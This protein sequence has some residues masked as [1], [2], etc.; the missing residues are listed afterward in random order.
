MANRFFDW[1]TRFPRF[2]LGDAPRYSDFNRVFD[3]I[4]TGLTGTTGF[5]ALPVGVAFG[6]IPFFT[7]NSIVSGTPTKQNY[8]SGTVQ[9]DTHSAFSLATG[10][11]TVPA[12]GAGYY[13]LNAQMEWGGGTNDTIAEI[14]IYK[15]GTQLLA[16]HTLVNGDRNNICR[17]AV[18]ADMLLA[19][20]DYIEIYLRHVSTTSAT[21]GTSAT[22]TGVNFF[23]M[24]Q[25]RANGAQG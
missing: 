11:F 13:N 19:A 3:W 12:T 14:L 20:G 25:F 21:R 9:Y 15:N 22:A 8:A 6:A 5:D 1:V 23:R 16:G 4:T 2:I 24:H 18:N 7:T 10:R 17:C